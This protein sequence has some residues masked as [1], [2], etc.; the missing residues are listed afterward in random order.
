MP[1]D[2][3]TGAG[4]SAPND[5]V[6]S[7]RKDAVD[8]QL[9][10]LLTALYD[11]S[12][13]SAKSTARPGEAL[14]AP[15]VA[16]EPSKPRAPEQRGGL[17][18]TTHIRP[19]VRSFGA[20]PLVG[21]ALLVVAILAPFLPRLSVGP[22]DVQFSWSSDE[23][24]ATDRPN[25]QQRPAPPS[26]PQPT[27]SAQSETASTQPPAAPALAETPPAPLVASSP[28]V[29]N[30]PPRE[31]EPASPPIVSAPPVVQPPPA[32]D[33]ASPVTASAP[34]VEVAPPRASEPEPPVVAAAP[35][36]TTAP[37]PPPAI[38]AAPPREV[39]PP[40]AETAPPPP[41]AIVAAPPTPAP[42]VAAAQPA[43]TEAAVPEPPAPRAAPRP[44][45]AAS[46][47]GGAQFLVQFGAFRHAEI[48]QKDCATYTKFA[49]TRL[50][51]AAKSDS[52][53][54]YLCRTEA[55][56]GRE[57]AQAVIATAASAGTRAVLVPVRPEP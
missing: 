22:N 15:P 24:S 53:V 38:A 47:A 56:Q 28:P 55:P 16:P 5:V 45:P 12:R 37:A 20:L 51:R 52:D 6:P 8:R 48:A 23:T 39:A 43:Q 2:P 44:A 21:G 36:E 46:A 49:P 10:T 11:A 17:L 33:S 9:D 27:S 40:P 30:A 50:I 18:E 29:E 14:L 1:D 34:P 31:P 4:A 32:L 19:P 35:P 42:S 57:E 25:A 7:H 26:E 54:W 13:L 41:P 3:H